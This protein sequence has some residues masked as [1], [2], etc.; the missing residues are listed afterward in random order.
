MKSHQYFSKII[1]L[2]NKVHLPK[3]EAYLRG[4]FVI[5]QNKLKPESTKDSSLKLDFHSGQK[6]TRKIKRDFFC[7][8]H[9]KM[10]PLPT[11]YQVLTWL[12][13]CPIDPEIQ[14]KKPLYS[15]FSLILL[16]TNICGLI[17]SG[18]FVLSHYSVDLKLSL[19]GIYQIA[20]FLSVT[21]MS[22]MAFLLRHEITSFLENLAEIYDDREYLAKKKILICFFFF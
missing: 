3:N 7:N 15:L 6:E 19:N 5:S 2:V 14:W 10:R 11:N 1:F 16:I 13:I 17:S 4:L 12:C 18:T 8:K 20:A 21:F 9:N 22:V